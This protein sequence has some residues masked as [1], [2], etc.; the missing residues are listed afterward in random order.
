MN[1]FEFLEADVF[2]LW[3]HF[4]NIDKDYSGYIS[5]GALFSYL[6][7]RSYSIVAP[8]LERFFDLID[9]E[10]IERVSYEELLPALVTFSLFSKDEM[11]TCKFCILTLTLV[12]FNM[13]DRDRDG[14]ISKKDLFRLFT[15]TIDNI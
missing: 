7:E 10:F 15:I 4:I 2:R 8:Y 5:I 13:F 11:I 12:V 9:R 14:E 1:D 3:K 6:N